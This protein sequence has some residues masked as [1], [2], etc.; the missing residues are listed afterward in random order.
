VCAAT[1]QG[2]NRRVMDKRWEKDKEEKRIG[3]EKEENYQR[4]QKENLQKCEKES[5]Q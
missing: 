4:Q 5:E 1:T 3:K 2:R